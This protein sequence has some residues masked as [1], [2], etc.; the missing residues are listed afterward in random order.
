MG[1]WQG[2]IWNR[3]KN[4]EVYP[5]LLSIG[6][7]KDGQG[8]I[9]GYVGVFADISQ[10]KASEAKMEFLAHHDPLTQLPNR[11]M[12][13]SRLEHSIERARLHNKQ[14]ALLMLDLDRFKDVN[15]SF[16]H[17]AGDEL[18]QQIAARISKHLRG[19]D[20]ISRLGGDEF[21]IL[22]EDMSHAADATLVADMLIDI[23][24]E[25]CQLKNGVEIHVGASIGISLYPQDGASASDLLQQA[26]AALYQAKAEGRGRFAYYAEQLT[27]NARTRIEMEAGLRRALEQQEFR[28][29]YQPQVDITTGRITGAEALIRWQH[30]QDGL[31]P[32]VL[33]IPVAEATGLISNIG[34]WVLME[35]CRQGRRWLDEG[36]PPLRL[37][38][39]VSPQ[40]LLHGDLID[41]V[42]R[43]LADSGFPATNLELELTETALMEREQEAVN[44]LNQLRSLG[45]HLAI[46]DF[47]TG[48]SSLAYLKSF[49]LDV[50]KID[51]SFVD[52]IPDS[53]DDKEIVSA[54]IAMGHKLRFR[55]LAEGVETA[56]QLAFLQAQ[57]CDFYQGYLKSPPLPAHEFAQLLAKA[58][59]NKTES[60][61]L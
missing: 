21:T 6:A 40:Q 19:V 58:G 52:D 22:L 56:E 3:R 30:P 57:D 20:T 48:Y 24:S 18:L 37:A 47:G 34:A 16:G 42:S 39:N 32:P 5:E 33:F 43:T 14:L 36:L 1:H 45:V 53:L 9:T 10:S 51:K 49:P 60:L 26:D 38:V 2:E 17:A 13:L 61:S 4:G 27:Q 41:M 46:D 50:L 44:V 11:L 28:V 54:I 59:G 8:N 35:T 31:I 15:D 55:V 12:L 29:Y 7:V 25:P 23:L